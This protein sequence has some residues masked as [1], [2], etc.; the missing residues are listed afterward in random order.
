M[1]QL[2]NQKISIKKIA[3]FFNIKY[4]KKNFHIE[5]VSSLNNIKNNSLLFYS[6]S[7]NF[8]SKKSNMKFDFKKL[9]KFENIAIISD[10]IPKKKIN[11]P[12]LFS[13]NPQFDFY[14]ITQ[15]FFSTS[16]FK[17]NIHKTA[18]IEKN[19]NL[20]Q[21][22]YI[23]SHCYIGNNVK[24]GDNTII[25]HNTCIYGKTEIG[26]GSVIKSNTTIGSEGFG[27]IPINK[28]LYHLPHVG[29]ILIGDN[30]WIGSNT[31]IEKSHIDQ[32]IIED[33][34]KIDDLV[35]IGHNTII[36]EF[37]QITAACIICGKAKIGKNCWI[38]P[39]SVIDVGCEIGDNCIVG[40]S[41][42][43]RSNFSKNS[44]VVGSPAKLLRKNV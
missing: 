31:T 14:R 22:V 42:L 34:V 11:V 18:I 12:I 17:N 27:F 37:T 41:S 13:T 6:N 8:V 5:T 23:G 30:V 19:S 3:S 32:T 36:K 10:I 9:E 4:T 39:N 38:S 43:V 33:H 28:E 20:G 26:S 25:L 35:Q 16:E 15:K 40:T 1:F 7:T 29:S 44:V 2:K 21:N 24:I